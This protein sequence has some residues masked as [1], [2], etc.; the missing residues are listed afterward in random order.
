[1]RTFYSDDHHLHHGRCELIDGKLM[2][3]FEMPSRADHVL[4]RVNDRQLGDV[5]APHDF[6]LAPLSRVHSE[7]YLAFFKGAWDRWAETGA[8]GDL[9]PYTWPA[10]TLRQVKPTSLHGEL[11]YYS[12]DGGAPITAGTWQAAYSAA[13]VALTGVAD[14]QQGAYSAFALCRP[15]GHHAAGELMGGYCYLNNAAIAAQAFLD[16]GRSRVA[17]LDVDYHHGNGTQSLFYTRNDVLFASIHGD[18][19]F[20]F[21]FFLGYADETGEGAGEGFNF[22]Y[23]L[24]A[25][26]GWSAWA[27]VLDQACDQI[28]RYSPDVLVVSLGVD[29]FKEDPISQFKLDSPDYLKMGERIARLGKPT[30]F[31]MEGGYAVEEIGINAVNVLEGFECACREAK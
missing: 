21:P 14:I 23:P 20:E 18:P 3:C 6:G 2:P 8:E 7:A 15:P 13:Q 29:T 1:M 10:R 17:V 26:S 24:P 27:A 9:L 25:G 11:G 31:V 30:L 5:H 12:F 28:D 19:A 16:Q 22:N 4:A